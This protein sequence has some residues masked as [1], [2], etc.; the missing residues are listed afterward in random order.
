MTNK[1]LSVIEEVEVSRG[2]RWSQERRLRFIDFRL[3]WQGR[4]NRMDLMKFFGISTPQASADITKYTELAPRNIVYNR[5]SRTYMRADTFEALF[6]SSGAEQYLAQLLAIDRKILEPAQASIGSPPP[7]EA[8]QIPNRTADPQI[9][10]ALLHAI[11][12]SQT[13]RASYQSIARDEPRWRDISP[14]AICTDGL[15]WHIRAYCHLRNGFRDFV[16]GRIL[17]LDDPRTSSI[18]SR[19][20]LEWHN[21]VRIVLAPHP[22][23]NQEQRHGVEIDYGMI[24]GDVTVECR[25]AMLF[26][27]LRTLNFDHRGIP[28]DGERQLVIKNLEELVPVLPQPGQA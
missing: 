10:A 4:L 13:V 1:N 15:R 21:M 24:G 2:P 20:D 26:Y 22:D 9:L 3:Q 19:E 7:T 25:Q 23:L 28:R 5:S 14:H 16:L 6:E 27:T 18:D 8:V 17:A 11:E 12:A